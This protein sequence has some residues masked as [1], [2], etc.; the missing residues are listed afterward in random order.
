MIIAER[1]NAYRIMWVLVLYDLPTETKKMRKEAQ[2][3]R[4]KLIKDGFTLFQFSMYV[5]NCPSRENAQV[6]INRVKQNLPQYG[7]I[8]IMC[9]TDKQFGDM[10]FFY[11]Q[12][13]TAAPE[14]YVQL[15]LF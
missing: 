2:N 1:Y 10:E 14:T 7:N 15:E 12:R 3:F 4:D 9:L 13:E 11:C 6:H 5:R 8:A